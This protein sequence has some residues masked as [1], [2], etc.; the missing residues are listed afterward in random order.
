MHAENVAYFDLQRQSLDSQRDR[1]C[2]SLISS[3]ASWECSRYKL[4]SITISLSEC[5]FHSSRVA[6]TA[7]QY[8]TAFGFGSWLR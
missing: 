7:A 8:S 3:H 2:H 6:S 4:I 5:V 1:W